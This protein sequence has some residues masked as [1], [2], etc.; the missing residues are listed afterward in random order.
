MTYKEFKAWA[1]QVVLYQA[2]NRKHKDWSY[3][4]K[5]EFN[6]TLR[7]IEHHTG[8]PRSTASRWI[9]QLVQEGELAFQRSKKTGKPG[10]RSMKFYRHLAVDKILTAINKVRCYKFLRKKKAEK[11]TQIKEKYG[12]LKYYYSNNKN[13][14]Q[15]MTLSETGKLRH[16]DG[17]IDIKQIDLR[18]KDGIKKEKLASTSA[19]EAAFKNWNL[20][21]GL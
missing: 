14:K 7:Q 21:L 17:W 8:I 3:H 1:K 4:R 18:R 6:F 15:R 13:K 12:T 16:D 9:R 2:Q 10:F 19:L 5:V 11:E 20:A